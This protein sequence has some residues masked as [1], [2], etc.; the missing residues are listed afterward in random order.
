[1][2]TIE[3]LNA[4]GADTKTGLA[5]CVNNQNL[6][7]RLVKTVP[8]MDAFTKLKDSILQH[9]YE[10]AFQ[11]AHGLKGA[12]TNL[13]LT[14]LSTPIIEITEHLRGKEEMDYSPLL[15]LIE[16]KRKELEE[17]CKD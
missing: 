16:E 15:T 13:S 9:D 17:L 3:N 2:L 1:M 7:F 12:L 6:Y 10:S 11:A 5:R 14:P 8:S 4:Y